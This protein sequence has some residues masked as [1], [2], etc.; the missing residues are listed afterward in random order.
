MGTL[1]TQ[2]ILDF[3]QA[4]IALA[5]AKKAELELRKKIYNHFRYNGKVEGVQH[6]SLDGLEIDIAI[7]LKL[8]RK[9]DTDVLDTI[10]SDLNQLQRDAIQYKPSLDLKAYKGLLADGEQGELMNVVTET[11]GLPTIKLN[12]VE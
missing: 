11:P 6:K 5:K 1:T 12:Y 10:W 9:L 7:T 3:E 4:Q 8:G 2:D